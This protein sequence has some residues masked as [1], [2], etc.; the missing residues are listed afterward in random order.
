MIWCLNFDWP[1]KEVYDEGGED[2]DDEDGDVD[3]TAE[4]LLEGHQ[5]WGGGAWRDIEDWYPQV[6][7][8]KII[9]LV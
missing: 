1:S 6:Q 5:A 9:C 4:G 7:P 2:E 8:V 3:V